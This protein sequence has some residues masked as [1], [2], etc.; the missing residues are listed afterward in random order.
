M[1]PL[2]S[3]I[4]PAYNAEATIQ[5]TI[6]SVQAQSYRE[7]E[8]LVIDDGSTDSTIQVVSE[9]AE[10]DNRIQIHSYANAGPSIARN[11]GI[12]QA[13]GEFLAFLDADD[14][15]TPEKISE[16]L[17][18]L[19]LSPQAGLAYSWIDWIDENDQFLRHGSHIA[20]EGKV[21]DQLL[22]RNFIDNGSN[23]LVRREVFE[24]IG[25]FDSKLPASEDWDM[26]LRIALIYDFVC[27]P[28]V[29]VYY[30][31]LK[32]SLSTNVQ[33]LSRANLEVL[34]DFF[35]THPEMKSAAG[36]RAYADKYRY[37]TFKSIEGRPCRQNGWLALSFFIMAVQLEP[38]WWL[39]RSHLIFI[40]LLKVILFTV[41][42]KQATA[43]TS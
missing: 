12:D 41:V 35:L 33:Q 36:R 29:Q 16:Q 5:A 8:I 4:I 34:D 22:L 42:P 10:Q 40:V 6:N 27:V 1:T 9:I 24:K 19:N 11:R 37:F 23:A 28:K 26:W 39:K 38:R 13:K 31:I 7:F 2:V 43:S 20:A 18:A 30:R 14:L 25:G 15:W 3:V 21:L 17:A 32:T